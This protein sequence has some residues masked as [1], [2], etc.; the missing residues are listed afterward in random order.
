MKKWKNLSKRG[1][2]MALAM[3]VSLSFSQITAFASDEGFDDTMAIGG[4]AGGLPE[5]ADVV[6]PLPSAEELAGMEMSYPLQEQFMGFG[7]SLLNGD[8]T[9]DAEKY[10]EWRGL[11]L[12]GVWAAEGN[13][14]DGTPIMEIDGEGNA[15]FNEPKGPMGE[16]VV[17]YTFERPETTESLEPSTPILPEGSG[18]ASSEESSDVSSEES[19][20]VSSEESSDAS[21]EE[22]SDASSEESSEASSEESSEAS[23]EESSEASSE[24]SSE[25]FSEE[26]N[27]AP[28]ESAPPADTVPE[29]EGDVD[30]PA[31][32]DGA[33]NESHDV[34][35][36]AAGVAV[37]SPRM[38]FD[39]TQG[40]TP[41]EITEPDPKEDAAPAETAP[42]TD[43]EPAAPAD[44]ADETAPETPAEPEM[45]TLEWKVVVTSTVQ[46]LDV[47]N[48][49]TWDE[50]KAAISTGGPISLGAD[51][52]GEGNLSINQETELNLNGHTI[53]YGDNE[54]AGPMFTVKKKFT[55]TDSVGEG[56]L[57]GYG[58]ELN[59]HTAL[60]NKDVKRNKYS[61]IVV[62]GGTFTMDGGAIADNY[63]G[64]PWYD[65]TQPSAV[66]STPG[67]DSADYSGAGVYVKSGTFTMNGGEISNNHT[68]YRGSGN[69]NLGADWWPYYLY[70]RTK[71]KGCIYD[72]PLGQGGGVYVSGHGVFNLSGGSI[73]ANGAGEGGGVFV[74]TTVDRSSW[75]VY[76]GKFVM[77]DGDVSGNVAN[78]GEGGGI[79]IASNNAGNAISGGSITDNETHTSEDLGGGGIYVENSSSLHLTNALV[80]KNYANGLGGGIAACVHGHVAL[81]SIDGVAAYENTAETEGYVQSFSMKVQNKPYSVD[82]YEQWKDASDFK[83]SATDV[84]SAG[85]R[86]N[87]GKAGAIVSNSMAGGGLANWTGW[88][89][90]AKGKEFTEV[91]LKDNGAISAKNLLALTANPIEESKEKAETIC[92]TKGVII[93]GNKSTNTHGGGIAT[94]GVLVLGK[95]GESVN[96]EGAKLTLNKTLTGRDLKAGEFTFELLKK[97]KV[98]A[99]VKNTAA[100]DGKP[101]EAALEIPANVLEVG[102]NVFIVRENQETPIT[103]VIYDQKEYTVK[104]MVQENVIKVEQDGFTITAKVIDKVEVCLGE[105]KVEDG[106]L[107]FHNKIESC[108][109]TV[110]KQVWYEDSS[111]KP[112]DTP[113]FLIQVKLGSSDEIVAEDCKVTEP[114]KPCPYVGEGVYN[115]YLKAGEKLTI[116]GIPAGMAYEITEPDSNV[117]GYKL[118][119]IVN[120]AGTFESDTS[121]VVVNHYYK[122]KTTNISV[123]KEWKAEDGSD[124]T[125]VKPAVT[126]QLLKDGRPEGDEITLDEGN[127]WRHQW[128]GL[129]EY[130]SELGQKHQYT[131]V[132]TGISYG[133]GYTVTKKGNVF[134]VE[135]NSTGALLG[136]WQSG[137]GEG[138]TAVEVILTNKWAPVDVLGNFSLNINKVD[139]REGKTPITGASFQLTRTGD[140]EF[141]YPV[142]K[143]VEGKI[144]FEGLPMGSYVLKETEPAPGYQANDNVWQ[145]SIDENGKAS[146]SSADGSDESAELKEN[147]I[148]IENDIIKGSISLTKTVAGVGNIPADKEFAFNVYAISEKGAELPAEAVAALKAVHGATAA[149]ELPYGWYAIVETGSTT[150]GGYRFNGVTFN[151][152][153]ARYDVFVGEHGKTYEVA[154]V[155]SYSVPDPGEETEPDTTSVSVNKVWVGDTAANRPASITVNLL[156][157]GEVYDT[158]TLSAGNG[159]HASWNNLDG[160]SRWSVEE[161][162]VPEGYIS[163]VRGTSAFTITNTFT[164]T[165]E[166]EP[167]EEV[168]ENDTPLSDLPPETAIPET[169]VPLAETP[170][171][172]EETIVDEK[173][174]LADVPKTGDKGNLSLWAALLAASMAGLLALVRKLRGASK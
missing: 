58:D 93:T 109:L 67:Y 70:Y 55:L 9:F 135:D 34:A 94:N 52:S 37:F 151:G 130:E 7:P 8:T 2:A 23:S 153:A 172:E 117:E 174:P 69:I 84:F 112:E 163:S 152:T 42:V 124:Y 74:G 150:I 110:E 131:V 27:E 68:I 5:D 4:L 96:S 87:D 30:A 75:T 156:R 79:Y 125:G 143:T 80:T 120:G 10:A 123:L 108:D 100:E 97:G 127:N 149:V 159:W 134:F 38:L 154:A 72:R 136:G 158:V 148:I 89:N 103:G 71:D 91:T 14:A 40:G 57:Q 39:E 114:V 90:D 20:D 138:S 25:A 6:V 102:E 28:S 22:S 1:L 145:I 45:V 132:E 141:T 33:A 161:A 86:D 29:G 18:E 78:L 49:T 121:A 140:K 50:L 157:N 98:I 76:N 61:L 44:T 19:S 155:N 164:T 16:A 107:N 60:D 35:D 113:E 95:E 32:E 173:I 167:E 65:Q 165:G 82:S 104:V 115:V 166:E 48:I 62:D 47:N 53:S 128:E 168:P 142:Q 99:S 3:T 162:D 24:E 54:P 46:L 59:G 51:I 126:V 15:T 139:S 88:K 146:V 21:S 64:T 144:T 63:K 31:G 13:W 129:P 81:L 170:I 105:E 66:G 41:E 106:I 116:S 119:E 137:L 122:A 147:T 111:V 17:T 26:S 160:D 36:D 92:R 101:A 133:E 56:K 77:T 43:P 12:D 83:E 73:N 169:E 118:Q 85:T 11:A 171:E